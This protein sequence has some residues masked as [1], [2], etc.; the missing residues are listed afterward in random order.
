MELRLF[1]DSRK[2]LGVQDM[3]KREICLGKTKMTFKLRDESFTV[4]VYLNHVQL[5]GNEFRG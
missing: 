4:Y 1:K 5:P 2:N 3:K